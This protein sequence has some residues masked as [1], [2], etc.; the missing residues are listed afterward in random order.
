[1]ILDAKKRYKPPRLRRRMSEILADLELASDSDLSDYHDDDP[2]GDFQKYLPSVLMS[3]GKS[4]C[5]QGFYSTPPN[6]Q[7]SGT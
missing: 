5:C 4:L 1:M 2:D 3:E 7:V 6:D